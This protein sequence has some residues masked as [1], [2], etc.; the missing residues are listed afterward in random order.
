MSE[1]LM[2]VEIDF[3][4][5]LKE[6]EMRPL[7]VNETD[8]GKVLIVKYNGE[9]YCVG[10]FCTH[11]GAQMHTGVL[12]ED[13]VMCPL[14]G[15]AF[16]ITTGALEDYPAQDPLPKF[17]VSEKNGKHYVHVPPVLPKK[18]MANLAKRDPENKKTFVIIGGGMA[19]LTCALTLRESDFTGRIVIVSEETL[20]PYDRTML[21]KT[22]PFGDGSRFLLR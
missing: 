15:A 3:A 2:E 5:D 10:N 1:E 14:H 11:F 13:K 22:L 16:N 6:G 12:F 20:L 9:I 4:S 7:K 21:T 8:D 17:E 18:G 19:G